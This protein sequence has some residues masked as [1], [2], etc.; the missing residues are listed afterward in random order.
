M[1]MLQTPPPPISQKAFYGLIALVVGLLAVGT[2]GYMVI[3][4]WNVLDSLYMVIITLATVGYK[5]VHAMSPA[6]T[7]FTI[8]LIVFGVITLYYVVRVVGE[9]IL[10][11]RLDPSY[12]LKKMA[13]V[14]NKMNGHYIVCGYGRVGKKIVSEFMAANIPVVVIEKDPDNVELNR[15]QGVIFVEGDST[16]EEMLVSA[17]LMN[18]KGFVASLGRDSDNI[19]AVITARSLNSNVFIVAKAN[20]DATIDKLLRVGANR[21]VSPYQI[22]AYR[23]AT[24]AMHPD[25]ADFV[26]NVVDLQ[27]SEIQITDMTVADT[28]SLVGQ[29][30]KQYLSNRKSGITVLVVNRPDGQSV[31][32]PLGDTIIQAGD[33]LILMGVKKNLEDIG[34]LTK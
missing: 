28:S 25:V 18:A 3:E 10:V 33:R 4:G 5:E 15:G 17:G 6:G 30:L 13:S 11:S 29:P 20:S 21:A 8:L 14:I 16:Q 31:I 24:F 22:S 32:N 19:L 9:Y 2:L 1:K 26:D 7:I 12:K 34:K 27:N 23:M